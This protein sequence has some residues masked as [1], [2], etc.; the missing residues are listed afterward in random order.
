MSKKIAHLQLKFN[1]LKQKKAVGKCAKFRTLSRHLAIEYEFMKEGKDHFPEQQ[2]V[3]LENI[4]EQALYNFQI[5]LNNEIKLLVRITLYK[6][7]GSN[8][9]VSAERKVK[10]SNAKQQYNNRKI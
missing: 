3:I 9:G 7:A 10:E 8:Q 4:K 1:S 5:D 6:L 2:R